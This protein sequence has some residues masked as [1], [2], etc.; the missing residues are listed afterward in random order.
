VQRKIF[1]SYRREDSAG[2]SGRIRDRL[3]RDFGKDYL[4]MDVDGIPLGTDFVK[5]LNDEVASCDVLLAVIGKQWSELRDESGGRRLDNPNDFVRIEIAAA[6]QRDIPLIP[7]LL[8]GT[9]IP[10]PGMLP[11]DMKELTARN[12]LDVRHASFHADLDRLV[13]ELKRIIPHPTKSTEVFLAPMV[14][15]LG[16]AGAAA[17][18]YLLSIVVRQSL[19]LWFPEGEGGSIL[20]PNMFRAI[21][22][23][24]VYVVIACGASLA[25]VIRYRNFK[26]VV[27]IAVGSFSYFLVIGLTGLNYA[28]GNAL[29]WGPRLPV[30]FISSLAASIAILGTLAFVRRLKK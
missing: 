20:P 28:M 30:A 29:D 24:S 13:S 2:Q 9:K 17:S 15:V 27:W 14:S 26:E 19:M 8:D 21:W 1:L 22:I 23:S 25:V 4:F 6:L 18:L 3:V 7:I 5:R 11:D 12:G 16:I 10:P